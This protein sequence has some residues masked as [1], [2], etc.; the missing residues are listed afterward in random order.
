MKILLLAHFPLP[1]G[2]SGIYTRSLAKY[3]SKN[4]HEVTVAVCDIKK[5]KYK[6]FNHKSILFKKDNDSKRFDVPLRLPCFNSNPFTDFRFIEMTK[7]EINIYL[8][9]LEKRVRKII[10]EVKPD[11]IHVQHVWVL[12]YIV[13]KLDIPYIFTAHNTDQAVF[14]QPEYKPF[15][16]YVKK[17]IRKSSKI[18]AIS[19]DVSDEVKKLYGVKRNKVVIIYN[20]IDGTFFKKDTSIRKGEILEKYGI[21]YHANIVLSVGRLSIEKGYKYLVRAARYYE[22]SGLDICTIIVGEGNQRKNIEEY[23]KNKLKNLYLLGHIKQSE[24]NELYNISD[25]LVV[26]SVIE[27]FGLVAA[28]AQ[29]CGTPVIATDAG[30]LPEIVNQNT[31]IIVKKKLRFEIYRAVI[32]ALNH[33]WKRS[34][35]KACIKRSKDLFSWENIVKFFEKEYEEVLD[36][37][38]NEI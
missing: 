4:G 20:G 1:G 17:G 5:R 19:K 30:G 15:L 9:T 18:I 7:K 38:K 23:C 28:E 13:S 6:S 8:E 31:G 2:G 37:N 21:N 27:G 14:V 12:G 11:I 26:P 36:K 10:E 25:I 34:K 33:N 22:N 16:P 35:G 29:I 3:L 32:L 24:L